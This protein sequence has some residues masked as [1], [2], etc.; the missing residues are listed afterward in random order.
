MDR[1][2]RWRPLVVDDELGHLVD[3]ELAR[4]HWGFAAA[5]TRF[6]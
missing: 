5:R 4:E 3:I 1:R 2:R 6:G